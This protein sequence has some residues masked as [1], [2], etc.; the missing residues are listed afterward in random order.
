MKAQ[1]ALEFMIISFI[2]LSIL[3]LLFSITTGSQLASQQE[4]AQNRLNSICKNLV[5]KINNAI[6]YGNGF[7]QEIVIPDSIY[8]NSYIIEVKNN[9]TLICSTEKFSLIQM[10]V[11][12]DIT[13]ETSN[14]PFDIKPNSITIENVDKMV[15]IK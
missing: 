11:E 10:F 3:L 14:P 2:I 12:N 15:V 13:N 8:G 5:N 9:K 6:Y 1:A 7:S 4:E